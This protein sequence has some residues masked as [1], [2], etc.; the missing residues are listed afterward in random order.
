M[1]QE[2]KARWVA[3]LRSGRYQQGTSALCLL[4]DSGEEWHCCLGV[5]SEIAVQDGIVV[6][7]PDRAVTRAWFGTDDGMSR[8]G[9][10]N[11]LPPQVSEWAHLSQFNPF[12]TIDGKT[13]HLASFND[14][15]YTFAQIADA[16]ETQL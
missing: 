10:F 3:A 11:Y 4:T 2:I 16:I 7:E 5:L 9:N 12:V 14:G 15:G 13:A 1:N 8:L 6:K